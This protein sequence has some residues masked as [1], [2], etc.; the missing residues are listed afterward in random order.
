MESKLIILSMNKSAD[1]FRK[2]AIIKNVR[3]V[4]IRTILAYILVIMS[5]C[6]TYL[7][8]LSVIRYL[9]EH[10]SGSNVE[11]F[12]PECFTPN[13][14]LFLCIFPFLLLYGDW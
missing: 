12:V 5:Y 14:P 2:N 3:Y 9:D 4:N 8:Q 6:S 7:G 1:I 13:S 11:H 10:G